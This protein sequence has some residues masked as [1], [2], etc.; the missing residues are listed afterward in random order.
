LLLFLATGR[1]LAKH[2]A[3]LFI[4][5]SLLSFTFTMNNRTMPYWNFLDLLCT[6]FCI[7]STT[8][9]TQVESFS[10]STTLLSLTSSLTSSSSSLSSLSS[11]DRIKSQTNQ[12]VNDH[13]GNLS[14]KSE[15]T[16]ISDFSSV[17][18]RRKFLH[19][20]KNSC[21]L[22][23]ITAVVVGATFAS[24]PSPSFAAVSSAVT[25]TAAA[26]ANGGV[27]VSKRAGGL[28]QKIRGGVCFKMVREIK[29]IGRK[30]ERVVDI[31]KEEN[32]IH[33]HT[34]ESS[35]AQPIKI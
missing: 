34:P 28:A 14:R 11:H 15:S 20:Q 10:S 32:H 18:S 12:I 29:R 5:L 31:L 8:T 35:W 27:K 4:T 24:T 25:T 9:L 26:A 17:S 21:L 3:C 33:T 7:V 2:F 1:L 30:R 22:T 16:L 19:Q 6:I 13:S 23:A